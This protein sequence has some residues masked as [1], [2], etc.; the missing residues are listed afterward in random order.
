MGQF[1]NCRKAWYFRNVEQLVPRIQGTAR[2]IG[3]AVHK[4]IETGS[5]NDALALYA[6]IF[7]NDQ[8]EADILETNKAIVQAMLEGYFERFG[9]GFP[10]AEEF[11]PEMKFE[12]EIINPTTG[13][14]SKSFK[15]SG[16]VDGII[17]VKGRWWL[18]EYK[19]AG[20]VGKSYIDKL[21]LDTQITTYIHAVQRQLNIKIDGVI[22]RVLRKPT[23]KQTKKET[24]W[25]YLD[26][27]TTDYKSRP[28]F[29]FFEERLYRS[30]NDLKEFESELWDLT[31]DMLKCR[32]ENLW[33]KNTS[34]CL[35]WGNC[36]FMPLCCQNPDAREMYIIQQSNSELEDGNDALAAS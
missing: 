21:A 35:D 36:E 11:I 22:Y 29:Y 2:G 8:T 18:V 5:V 32:R 33:Y 23:I 19:T 34:R 4:G 27:L 25:Q 17:K 15:L 26:R 10:E 3:S 28:E 30:Q 24:V 6:E 13:A 7:P 9:A 16:K 20:Q 12:V 14:K 31:Q 1:K